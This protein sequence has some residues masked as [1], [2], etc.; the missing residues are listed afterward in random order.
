MF[1][2][3]FFPCSLSHTLTHNVFI[4]ALS[5]LRWFRIEKHRCGHFIS[6]KW[7][8]LQSRLSPAWNVVSIWC[9]FVEQATVWYSH[10]TRRLCAQWSVVDVCRTFNFAWSA[11][12]EGTSW[13][14]AV[15]RHGKSRRS[16]V[17]ASLMGRP[18]CC[19]R[20]R[21]LT[22]SV[23]RALAVPQ[24]QKVMEYML[25]TLRSCCYKTVM[26]WLIE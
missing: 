12:L 19:S 15:R 2:F 21:L 6:K 11:E 10:L 9:A 16:R 24:L 8:I 22:P 20:R 26:G 3:S 25:C 4:K 7:S 1:F 5:Y 14:R 18:R 23:S 13:L 17:A